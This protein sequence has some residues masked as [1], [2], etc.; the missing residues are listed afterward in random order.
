[1][2]VCSI[3]AWILRPGRSL[4]SNLALMSLENWLLPVLRVAASDYIRISGYPNIRIY[5]CYFR[6]WYPDIMYKYNHS[7]TDT[8]LSNL[9]LYRVESIYLQQN[10]RSSI[11]EV[12]YFQPIGILFIGLSSAKKLTLLGIQNRCFLKDSSLS[13]QKGSRSEVILGRQEIQHFF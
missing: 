1:M 5:S 6:I 12:F 3:A 10:N 9:H 13:L 7:I 8:N 4:L 11:R 2:F